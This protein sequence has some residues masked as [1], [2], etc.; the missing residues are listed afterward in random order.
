MAQRNISPE[1]KTI[2]YIGSA[3]SI[4]GG[5]LFF[6]IFISGAMRFGDFSDFEARTRSYALRAVIGMAM[7][8]G[9]AIMSNVGRAGLAGSGVVLDPEKSRQ[10]LEPWSRMSGGVLKDTLDE[11][12]LDLSKMGSDPG[13]DFADQLRKLHELYQD[14][15]LSE[16]EYLREKSELL[17]KN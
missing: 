8:I 15:I 14:G 6:S 3:I 2:F 4:I 13:D 17:D 9:G 16:E 10:D 12:G 7:F 11:A 1:R 5:L